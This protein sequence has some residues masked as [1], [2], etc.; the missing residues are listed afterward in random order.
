MLRGTKIAAM[1]AGGAVAA[2]LAACGDPIT[3]NHDWKSVSA[4][5]TVSERVGGTTVAKGTVLAGVL[6]NAKGQEV[7]GTRF[8]EECVKVTGT[9]TATNY[10]CLALL[11]AGQKVYVA[12]GMATGPFNT[13]KSVD[14]A[15]SPDSMIITKI[16]QLP[17]KPVTGGSTL[18]TKVP[19]YLVK[20]SA[21]K[22]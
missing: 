12:G 15:G 13:L 5:V 4:L 10:R 11:N 22:G 14:R 3:A 21:R 16:K 19:V 17:V 20:I 7:L 1:V 9:G 18:P 8:K 6:L 2:G